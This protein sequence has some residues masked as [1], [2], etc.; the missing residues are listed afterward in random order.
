MLKF[1]HTSSDLED[2]P[3]QLKSQRFSTLSWTVAFLRWRTHYQ[4]LVLCRT[5]GNI[6]GRFI[7]LFEMCTR[8]RRPRRPPFDPLT[9]EVTVKMV[10]TVTLRLSNGLCHC[11]RWKHDLLLV[12]S[13]SAGRGDCGGKAVV[14]ALKWYTAQKKDAS[15][16]DTLYGTLCTWVDEKRNG[17]ESS[18][19]SLPWLSLL[20]A[21]DEKTLGWRPWGNSRCL[22]LYHRV[23]LRGVS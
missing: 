16:L 15:G 17:G 10:I 3:F 23:E 6:S 1:E 21:T 20:E 12:C 14:H 8:L 9:N 13:G 7:L 2:F 4:C 19:L 11:V 5:V 18:Q 22:I